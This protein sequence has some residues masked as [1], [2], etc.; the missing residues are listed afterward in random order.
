MGEVKLEHRV[1]SG[2]A[3]SFMEKLLTMVVQM[4]VSIVVARQLS[5]DDFGVMAI[6]TFFTSVAL[7]VVDSGFSQT[8][9]RK[10]EPTAQEYHSVLCFNVVVAILLYVVLSLVAPPLARFY[11]HQAIADVAPVLFLVLPINS[12]CVVQTVMFTREF[13]FKL[14]SNIVLLSSLVSGA[15]AV[16]MA[17]MGCGIWSLVAQRLLQMGLKAVAFWVI[18]RWHSGARFSFAALRQMA[19]FSL[20]LLA[21]DLIASIY[22]NVAQLF[23]GKM[24]STTALGYYAQAQKL[25]DLP[26]ISTVQAVQGVTY[27]ALSKIADDEHKFAAGYERIVRLLAYLLFPTMLGLVAIAPEMFMLLLGQKWMPTVPYFEIL[28]LS[29]I[30]YPLS[31]VA[32]N[33]LKVRGDGRV[34]LRLELLKRVVM[35]FVLVYT[36]PRGVVA[37]AWG[38]TAMALVDWLM[39]VIA[40]ER[41]LRL[42]VGAYLRSLLPALLLAGVMFGVLHLANPHLA[43]LTLALRLVAKIG[44]GV[45]VYLVGSLCCGV[46]SLRECIDL[47]RSMCRRA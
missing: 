28:A 29:G 17:L 24:H 23:I 45:V 33:I 8:L 5:P 6:L 1:A 4:V 9:I 25:K 38:M 11:G 39:N 31:V 21:T 40:S 37:V 16:T 2:V 46:R 3:W 44:L 47:L 7:A 12:L 34:I 22:N 14:L 35:T 36:I 15:V 43:G 32:Y 13:R 27:P 20:R 41:Y 18:R 10:R 30:F 19:P 26:V 42:G